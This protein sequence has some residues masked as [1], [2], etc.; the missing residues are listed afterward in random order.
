LSLIPPQ[1]DKSR[2]SGRLFRVRAWDDRS[3]DLR[4]VLPALSPV[5][6]Y[7]PATETTR[8]DPS[9]RAGVDPA[10][11]RCRPGAFPLGYWRIRGGASWS[12]SVRRPAGDRIIT[13]AI[14]NAGDG[15]MQAATEAIGGGAHRRAP[16]SGW[17]CRPGAHAVAVRPVAW[18]DTGTC[19]WGDADHGSDWQ[20]RRFRRRSIPTLCGR[21][22]RAATTAKTAPKRQ[23]R[24]ATCPVVP[25]HE[26]KP[27][28][29]QCEVRTG[30]DPVWRAAWLC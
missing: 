29:V 8:E 16:S 26:V 1:T 27:R 5:L 20:L 14:V 12:L 17:R 13:D 15:A 30:I 11:S 19:A 6:S 3:S 2:P 4:R 24:S 23:Q 10:I 7:T 21:Q 25:T 9:R 22:P 18:R 28:A